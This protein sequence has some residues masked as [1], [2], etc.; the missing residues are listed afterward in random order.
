MDDIK[1]SL[2]LWLDQG[3]RIAVATV[4]ST[5]GSSPRPAGS[6]M[7]VT[8]SG[9][10]A[11]SVSAGC[12]EN[13]VVEECTEV[14]STGIPKLLTY[15]IADETAWE[16]GLT[17]GGTIQVF[18]E[19]FS[20]MQPIYHALDRHLST[21]TP[22]AVISVIE[23]DPDRIGRKLLVTHLK[24]TEGNLDLG[25][26][27]DS[28]VALAAEM[29]ARGAASVLELPDGS[30][31]FVDVYPAV[32][33]LIIVG[34][35]HIAEFLVPMANTLGFH[36]IVVD[37][38]AAFASQERFPHAQELI[39]AWPQQ[40][41][42]TVVLDDSAYVITLSHDEKIDD[43]ALE[44]ALAS[45]ARYVG[46]LGSRTTNQKRMERLREAGLTDEQLAR[47]HAPVGLPLGGR[48]PAE[49]A[50]SAIAQIV[51]VRYAGNK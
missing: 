8:A 12:V 3:E 25:A 16:V 35:V 4:I 11:G 5:W 27:Q 9:R 43:P 31:A 40:A 47:L 34:A 26:E 50:L 51:Q 41:L 32:P 6:K 19:P 36:T 22:V 30:R 44:L 2:E 42:P 14:L 38:R 33:R 21:H 28:V 15:G 48:S 10:I 46:A 39:K 37:P 49:I 20:A 7:G 23:G 1:H 45:D 13:A 29:L 18:V 17:C 24:Q